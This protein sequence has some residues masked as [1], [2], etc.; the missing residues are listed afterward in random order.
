MRIQL[1]NQNPY[2]EFATFVKSDDFAKTSLRTSQGVPRPISSKSASIYIAMFGK[3]M[4]WLTSQNMQ[5][6]Q[7]TEQ[8]LVRFISQQRSH[9]THNSSVSTVYLRLLER[10]FTHLS[11]RPNPASAA[12]KVASQNHYIAQNKRTAALES[13][14]ISAF[15][16]AL[17]PFE[18]E[19]ANRGGRAPRAWK[20]RR[21]HAMQATMLFSGLRVTEAIGLRL[22]EIDD[23][24]NGALR[25]TVIVL[26]ITPEG[27]HDTSHDHETV[28]RSYGAV[29]LRR[30]L[31]ERLVLGV[32]GELVFPA[33]LSGKP[34]TRLTVYRQVR[35]TFERAGIVVDRSGGRTLRNTFAVEELR[36]GGNT[37]ELQQFL[38]L[39]L[40]R[41]AQIYEPSKV[42]RKKPA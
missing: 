17:P 8:D 1:W 29:A 28:L 5:F 19:A 9:G 11:I 20:R 13:S 42:K 34:M 40:E 2:A 32:D 16:D 24:F 39:A 36:F 33:D 3:F 31:A 14:E 26:K 23:S 25:D 30:W 38:G 7:L 6:S 27:K 4:R 21:D 22:S 41:S 12:M 37:A 10:C 18:P 15:I 35:A